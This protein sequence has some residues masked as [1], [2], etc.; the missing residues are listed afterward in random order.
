MVSKVSI[1]KIATKL[2]VTNVDTTCNSGKYIIAT[3][4]DANGNPVSGVMVGFA[5][6]GV[7]YVETDASGKA[8][9]STD[10]F[11][12]GS[13]NV[14]VAFFGDDDYAASGKAV[15]KVTISK[16]ATKLIV[17]NVDTTYKSGK[18]IIAVLTDA[19]GKPISNVLI[20]F[21]NN[22]VKYVSTDANGIAKYSTDNFEVGTY[23]VNVAFFGDDTY[24][25]S[26]R[27]TSKVVIIS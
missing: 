8:R 14:N 7:Q 20:G 2:T 3:L 27:L 19:N 23:N 12:E 22:G 4:T 1:S 6:N 26:D 11:D 10:H 17:N 5:N 13:H 21:A 16:V 15:S 25:A 24:Q 18:N 9:Y